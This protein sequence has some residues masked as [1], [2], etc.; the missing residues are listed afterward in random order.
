MIIRLPKFI[1][2]VAVVLSVGGLP[3][4]R[5]VVPVH[6]EPIRVVATFSILG[7]WVG[8]VG[9]DCV[10]VA[11]L[12]GADGDVHVFD[13]TARDM[14]TLRKA[15]IIFAN[16]LGLESWLDRMIGASESRAWVISLAEQLPGAGYSLLHADGSHCSHESHSVSSHEYDP[17]VWLDPVYAAQMVRGIAAVLSELDPSNSA[18]YEGN[19]VTYIER[20]EQ[21]DAYIEE[22]LAAIPAE[23]RVLVAHHDSLRYFARRYGFATPLSL[24][25]AQTT[26]GG[27]PEARRL[28]TLVRRIRASDIPAVFG[29]RSLPIDLPRQVALE[30]GL[31]DPP[32]LYTGA[33]GPDGSDGDNYLGMMTCNADIILKS[34]TR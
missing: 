23:R 13:P 2:L 4:A 14:L 30:A 8:H 11:T 3:L 25:G 26:D 22:E 1:S 24:I 7:E 29:E 12:I 31:P 5:A 18:Y 34:L 6:G 19:A 17:H 21:L 27:D 16:G 28:V 32:P 15:D 10:E 33:L 9:G 20:L